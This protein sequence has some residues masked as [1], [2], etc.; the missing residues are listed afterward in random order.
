MNTINIQGKASRVT[1]KTNTGLY[2]RYTQ[3]DGSRPAQYGADIYTV[4]NDPENIVLV[5]TSHNGSTL[6]KT[7]IA[8]TRARYAELVELDDPYND[9]IFHKAVMAE[10]R[11]A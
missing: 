9:V 8:I 6:H 7:A 4:D 10:L 2:T 11:F 3:P 5:G 1:Y